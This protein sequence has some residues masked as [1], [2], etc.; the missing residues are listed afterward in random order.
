MKKKQNVKVTEQG[1]KITLTFNPNLVVKSVRNFDP[2]NAAPKVHKA[3]KGKGSYKRKE[4]HK[5]RDGEDSS[6]SCFLFR[7]RE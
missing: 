4:K 7:I 1:N 2:D 6:R 3:G 5:S